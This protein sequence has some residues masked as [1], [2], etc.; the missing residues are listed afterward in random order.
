VRNILALVLLLAAIVFSGEA[1][2]NCTTPC[3][4]AQIATDI[5]TNWPDNTSGAI[6]PAL[7]RSTVLDLVN[8]YE[9]INGS[10]SFTCGASTWVSSRP[11]LS[12]YTCTQPAVTDVSGFGT[13]VATAL[14]LT[15][16]TGG[17]LL[18]ANGTATLTNKTLDT[19]GP[20]TL[21]INGVTV[22]PG[23]YP[24]TATNDN[25][26]SGNIGEYVESIVV[27]GSA[28]SQTT[29]TPKNI[30]SITLAAGDWDVTGYILWGSNA[31]TNYTLLSGC[32]ST[33]SATLDQTVGRYNQNSFV[34]GVVGAANQAWTQG[35]GPYRFSLSGSTTIF[36][37]SQPVFS[38]GTLVA[39]GHLHARRMR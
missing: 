11:T 23:Q 1:K 32:F 9:D 21:K 22:S 37:V 27:F 29:N 4:K 31:S 18:T 24:G 28:V 38:A 15:T 33:T 7:L 35:I 2:A 12:S 36:L 17:G 6:T 16:N 34:A 5:A 26:T 19:A 13:G 10:S 8:S 20:N 3:T 39:Y 14:A 30:T 25:A